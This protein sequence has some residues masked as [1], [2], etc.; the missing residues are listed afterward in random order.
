MKAFIVSDNEYATK[1]YEKLSA[2]LK[3]MLLSKGFEIEETAI[4]RNTLAFC[5][6]C[7]GCWIK[8]PGEC[9]ISDG[10][11]DLNR[12]AM[13]SDLAVYLCPIVFGQYSANMKC[14]I[15]RWLP[16]MLPFFMTR[17]D[18]STMHPPRYKSYPYQIMIGYGEGLFEE[19]EQLFLDVI[20]KHRSNVKAFVY[21][22]ETDLSEELEGVELKRVEGNL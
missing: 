6:G 11:A 7:F 21:G 18:G 4:D 13:T 14:V 12:K 17:P 16:N 3:D 19:D 20:L 5:K 1:I 8:T 15:D 9:V 22:K 2:Q 10:I